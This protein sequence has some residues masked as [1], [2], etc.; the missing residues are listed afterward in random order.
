MQFVAEHE[1]IG[2]DVWFAHMVHLTDDEIAM[3]AR[4]GTG[5]AHCPQS[6]ARLGSGIARIPEAMAAGVPIGL[7]VDG[8]ASNEAAD[9]ANEAYTCWLI[10]R[11]D[12]RS[13]ERV[14]S[15]AHASRVLQPG[16]HAGAMTAE[17]VVHLGTAGGLACSGWMAL[18]RSRSGRLPIWP[19][20]TSIIPA[21][22]DCTTRLRGRWSAVDRC[23][24]G[25]CWF[26]GGWSSRTM[27]SPD[28]IFPRCAAMRR[29]L[30]T[31]PVLN[32]LV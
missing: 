12:P 16:G 32:E 2:S 25:P 29:P 22:S 5:I 13:G 14:D 9:M 6:N 28:S 27:R 10:H 23:R 31:G 26:R 3:C 20:M 8:A 30:S 21:I 7:A 17:D 15:R 1:W 18:A 24:C 19:S 11:A 4:T